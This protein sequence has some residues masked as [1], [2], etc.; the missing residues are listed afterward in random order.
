MSLVADGEYG[1]G[2]REA[3]AAAYA[4]VGI[5]A[6]GVPSEDFGGLSP[7][8]LDAASERVLAALDGGGTVYLHCRAGWQRSVV[9]AA[10]V[11]GRRRGGT[12]E[13]ALDVV[14]AHR[15]GACPLPHQ[16]EDLRRWWAA[17]TA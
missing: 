14:L 5:T 8:V 15:R 1:P 3:A 16:V 2:E 17:G 10:A 12:P 13:Q 7:A 6:E 9:V 4:A 11:L